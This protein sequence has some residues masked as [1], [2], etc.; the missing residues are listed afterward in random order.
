MFVHFLKKHTSNSTNLKHNSILSHFT[1]KPPLWKSRNDVPLESARV[2][3]EEKESWLSLREPHPK[4]TH[5]L[6]SMI[7]T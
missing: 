5:R 1:T 6:L 4:P 3:E 2:T 7:P